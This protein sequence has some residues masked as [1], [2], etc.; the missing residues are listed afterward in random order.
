MVKHF[1]R[2]GKSV[3]E[4]FLQFRGV[5]DLGLGVELDV[6]NRGIHFWLGRESSRFNDLYDL[7]F[8]EIGDEIGEV[9][10]LRGL[11]D[12]LFGNLFLDNKSDRFRPVLR[13]Q[14]LV[15]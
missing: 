3:V 11:C 5:F 14:Y 13:V 8:P 1:P 4:E 15:N 12:D 9:S 10:G 2:L 6:D 7:R